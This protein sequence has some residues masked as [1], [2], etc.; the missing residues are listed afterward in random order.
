MFW[1]DQNLVILVLLKFSENSGDFGENSNIFSKILIIFWNK[2]ENRVDLEKRGKMRPLS[3][4][5][6][7]ILLKSD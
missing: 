1:N 2:Y 4:S 3:L 5:E 7:P 6:V